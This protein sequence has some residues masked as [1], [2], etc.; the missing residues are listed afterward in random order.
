VGCGG[1]GKRKGGKKKKGTALVACISTMHFAASLQMDVCT[2]ILHY[3]CWTQPF[4][5]PNNHIGLL[6]YLGKV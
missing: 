2:T 1:G 4:L 3:A 6:A 5:V